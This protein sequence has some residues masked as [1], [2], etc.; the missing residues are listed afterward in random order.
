MKIAEL[1]PLKIYPFTLMELFVYQQAYVEIGGKTKIA[2]LL[3]LKI[4]LHLSNCLFTSRRAYG[5][6][7]DS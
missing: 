2:E 7:I 6:H 5:K 1:L 3:L 4:Y